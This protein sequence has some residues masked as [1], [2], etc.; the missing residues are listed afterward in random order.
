MLLTSQA[1]WIARSRDYAI[2]FRR[3]AIY[4]YILCRTPIFHNRSYYIKPINFPKLSSFM[5]TFQNG[6]R[7][8]PLVPQG[9]LC[10]LSIILNTYSGLSGSPR[11]KTLLYRKICMLK[12][13]F[14]IFICLLL[15][16]NYYSTTIVSRTAGRLALFSIT[17]ICLREINFFSYRLCTVHIW[18]DREHHLL[19][20][21][22]ILRKAIIILNNSLSIINAS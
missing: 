13:T 16:L 3:C 17:H 12:L 22:C 6:K 11:G 18:N 5:R 1:G 20:C 8:I 7:G 9:P 19:R 2:H 21:S 14:I 15:L 10:I 4:I